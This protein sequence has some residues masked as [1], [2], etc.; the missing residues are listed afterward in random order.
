MITPKPG[1]FDDLDSIIAQGIAYPRQAGIN[2][3]DSG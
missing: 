1:R 2:P 3:P